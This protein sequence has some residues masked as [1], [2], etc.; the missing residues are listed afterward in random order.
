MFTTVLNPYLTNYVYSISSLFQ[1][2]KGA[3]YADAQGIKFHLTQ[4]KKLYG[5]GQLLI[6]IWSTGSRSVTF[7]T[8]DIVF[9]TWYSH[10]RAENSSS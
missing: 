9:S 3:W 6:H 5:T 4:G 1:S 10:R 8:K 2:A 7:F